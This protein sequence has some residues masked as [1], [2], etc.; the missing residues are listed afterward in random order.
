M[1]FACYA[2]NNNR[3]I[4]CIFCHHCLSCQSNFV[5]A[6]QLNKSDAKESVRQCLDQSLPPTSMSTTR[7]FSGSLVE[8][9]SHCY[10]YKYDAGHDVGGHERTRERI[11]F[12]FARAKFWRSDR[13]ETESSSYWHSK[14]PKFL[15]N[16]IYIKIKSSVLI[17]PECHSQHQRFVS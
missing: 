2:M 16:N 7:P 17:S 11:R 8:S 9:P 1:G 6:G 5:P 15:H 12:L 3:W 4:W 14:S 10:L 13:N